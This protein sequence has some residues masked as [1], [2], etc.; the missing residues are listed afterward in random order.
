MDFILRKG[1][2]LRAIE[3]KSNIDPLKNPAMD[4][5][6]QKYKP[7]RCLLIGESGIPLEEFLTAPI[8]SLV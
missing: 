6:V 7:N 1:T 5:S 8:D 4:S 3:V 2:S